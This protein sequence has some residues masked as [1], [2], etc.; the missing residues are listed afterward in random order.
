MAG[1]QPSRMAIFGRDTEL[2][3]L[4][5]RLAEPKP[6]LFHGPSGIGKTLLLKSCCAGTAVLY[7][8]ASKSPQAL[9]RSVAELLYEIGDPT[10]RRILAGTLPSAK[11]ARSLKGVVLDALRANQRTLVIDQLLRP[12]QATGGAVREMMHAGAVIVSVAR[13]AH[14]EDAGYVL[15]LYP[16]K[17]EKLEIRPFDPKTALEFATTNAN[18]FGILAENRQEFLER[19]VEYGK[20]NPGVMLALLR[21]AV[22]PKYRTGDHIKIAPLYIDFRLEWNAIP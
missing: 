5:R 18:D 19:V 9:F 12:S 10:T 4:K 20:G 13:S 7:T 22:Q 8:A 3:E 6:F 21:K 1:S 17:E 2:A 11:S 15:A 16:Y 14:M